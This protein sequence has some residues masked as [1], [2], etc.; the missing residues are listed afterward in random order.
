MNSKI[1][2]E[3]KAGSVQKSNME[4]L[5]YFSLWQKEILLHVKN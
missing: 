3:N 1:H 5:S 4:Y 2:A